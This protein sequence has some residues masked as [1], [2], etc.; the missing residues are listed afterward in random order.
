PTTLISELLFVKII[1]PLTQTA[2]IFMGKSF[3]NHAAN[4]AATMPPI[5]KDTTSHQLIWLQ[6]RKIIKL[7]EADN[8]KKNSLADTVTISY[9]GYNIICERINV[10]L[11]IYHT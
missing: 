8:V 6:P 5:L 3:T 10:E 7:R 2:R 9:Q 1:K 4:G 11:T